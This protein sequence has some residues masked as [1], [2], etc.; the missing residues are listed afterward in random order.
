MS[1]NYELLV[2]ASDWGS[3]FRRDV[4][5]RLRIRIRDVNDNRPQFEQTNCSGFV[6]RSARPRTD[7][8]RLSAVDFDADDVVV[9]RIDS[10]NDDG[11]FEVDSRTGQLRTKSCSRGLRNSR[12][13]TRVIVVAA[14]DGQHQTKTAVTVTLVSNRR[15]RQLVG[16][17]ANVVCR[18][19]GVADELRRIADQRASVGR[20][21]DSP[22]S[23]DVEPNRF[24]RN[25][26]A[27]QFP[28]S[29]PR[30]LRVLEGSGVRRITTLQAVDADHGYN[31]R[32]MYVLSGG[33]DEDVFRIDP[34][35]GDLSAVRTLDRELQDRYRLNVTVFDMG[36]PQR[37][38]S[39]LVQVDV[40]DINDNAPVFER[41][42]YIVS[43][44][45]SAAVG[46]VVVTVSAH[47]RDV[48]DNGRV[49]YRL[50]AAAAGS[51]PFSINSATGEIRLA[52]A[53]DRE[54]AAVHEVLVVAA[55]RS[56]DSPMSGTTSLTVRVEDINDNPP[57]FVPPADY[58]VRLLEDLPVGTVVGTVLA[59][60]PD[61]G[62]N[63]AVRYSI[64]DG[65]DGYF[66]V[67]RV[68][69]V[70]RLARQASFFLFGLLPCGRFMTNF[71]ASCFCLLHLSSKSRSL[72]L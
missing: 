5:A 1:R 49:I 7:L 20:T 22:G 6:Y 12:L 17:D 72:Y 54:T 69:G 53:L 44:P 66:T 35:S 25:L 58:R 3:P 13:D 21:T 43:V 33:N 34:E 9:Y 52:A 8:V 23:P 11:C 51:E 55:D 32:L 71:S 30:T 60:D 4:E 47:D 57:A 63:G 14:T 50:G 18:E 59:V 62:N 36:S 42:S 2:R 29:T 68:T 39:R 64:V 15:N 45:E 41:P 67:D 37:S 70:V 38:S 10:G 56:P 48:G 26:H 28:A 65:S 27:P 61:A 19:T 46:T 40:E 31:G 24:S 16:Q